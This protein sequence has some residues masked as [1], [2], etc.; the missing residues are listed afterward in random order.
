MGDFSLMETFILAV[1][2]ALF[3]GVAAWL[4]GMAFGMIAMLPLWQAIYIIIGI[5]LCGFLAKYGKID[6][7]NIFRFVILLGAVAV[8]GI[9][10]TTVFPMAAPYILGVNQA[11]TASG[12]VWI[13]VY[14]LIGEAGFRKVYA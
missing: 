5:V 4:L 8:V 12:L 14:A 3:G 7:F 6:E 2:V 1:F 11:F 10:I 13:F 9:F